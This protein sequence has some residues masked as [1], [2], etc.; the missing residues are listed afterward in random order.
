MFTAMI[1]TFLA[2]LLLV[3]ST[4]LYAYSVRVK[5]SYGFKLQNGLK[6]NHD[7]TVRVEIDNE[8]KFRVFLPNTQ[9]FD[10]NNNQNL[11][12]IN[13]ALIGFFYNEP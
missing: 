3:Y 5:S 12:L 4:Q 2:S 9:S 1:D 10:I 13:L 6:T 7:E 11:L 8:E